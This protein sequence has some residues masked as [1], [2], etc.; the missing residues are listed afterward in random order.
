MELDLQIMRME[1]AMELDLH[2][3]EVGQIELDLQVIRIELAVELDL[4][5]IGK[6]LI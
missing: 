5:I 6:D 2:I 4:Q 1:L 3:I